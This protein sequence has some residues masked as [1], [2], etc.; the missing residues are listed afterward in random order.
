MR[1][2]LDTN[3]LLSGIFWRGLPGRIVDLRVEGRFELF[4]SAPILEEYKR[5]LRRLGRELGTEI[6]ETWI[7]KIIEK[8]SV[9]ATP[10]LQKRWSRD[11]KDDKF[12]HCALAGRA[13][14]LVTGDHDLLEL[15]DSV[16]LKILSPREFLDERGRNSG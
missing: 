8:A 16:P 10:L 5:V 2:C 12:V 6:A 9:V 4:V 7:T 3:V 14:Y 11:P 1:V 13:E 15:K